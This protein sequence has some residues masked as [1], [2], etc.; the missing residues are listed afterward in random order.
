MEAIAS[1]ITIVWLEY[2]TIIF[3]TVDMV[4]PSVNVARLLYQLCLYSMSSLIV[5][6][7][8]RVVGPGTGLLVL[9]KNQQVCG[10]IH[11]NLKQ[12]SL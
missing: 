5:H 9:N 4:L 1:S 2:G 8:V 3:T 10:I 7:V 12:K 6:L 11:L